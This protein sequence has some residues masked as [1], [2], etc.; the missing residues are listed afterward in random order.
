M[1]LIGNFFN[2]FM[3]FSHGVGTPSLLFACGVE[4]LVIFMGGISLR[5]SS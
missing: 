1:F 5:S 3:I 4:K 2:E